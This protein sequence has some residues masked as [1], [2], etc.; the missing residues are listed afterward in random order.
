LMYLLKSSLD[1][2][3]I[4]IYHTSNNDFKNYINFRRTQEKYESSL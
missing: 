4:V 3:S 2:N 1:Q